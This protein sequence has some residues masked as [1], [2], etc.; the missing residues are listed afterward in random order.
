MGRPLRTALGDLV[1]GEQWLLTPYPALILP[2]AGTLP[3]A[4]QQVYRIC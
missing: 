3:G 4:V 1:Y 2:Q